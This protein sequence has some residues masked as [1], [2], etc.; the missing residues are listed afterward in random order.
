MT[1]NA[2]KDW[3]QQLYILETTKKL[4]E[5]DFYKDD[6]GNIVMTESYHIKR[7]SCCGSK[8]THC[9]FDPKWEKGSTQI[10]ESLG[11]PR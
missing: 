6:M 2:S 1:V 9:P 3:I 5:H 7:G 10:R 4:P 11:N 8:C